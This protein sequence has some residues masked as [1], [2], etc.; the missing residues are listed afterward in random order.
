MRLAAQFV[1]HV[2]PGVIKPIR[3]LW[4]EI[5]GFLFLVLATFVSLASYR[6]AQSFTGDTGEFML[7]VGYFG[8]AALLAFYGVSSFWKARKISR[9]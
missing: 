9:S 6:R 5:I 4:N 8:F 2:V 7:L 3:V 1:K